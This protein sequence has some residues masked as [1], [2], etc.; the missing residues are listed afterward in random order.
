MNEMFEE[1]DVPYDLRDTQILCQL[2]FRNITHEKNTLKYYSTHIW[3]LL[4]NDLKTQPK[5]FCL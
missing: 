3:N 2:I 5:F 4:H 1:K